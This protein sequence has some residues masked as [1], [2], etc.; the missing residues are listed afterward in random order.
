M[1]IQSQFLRVG[2]SVGFG[3]R[4]VCRSTSVLSMKES[5]AVEGVASQ[6]AVR[7]CPHWAPTTTA[8]GRS[9]VRVRFHII[10]HARIKNVGKYQACMVSKLPIV[11]KQTVPVRAPGANQLLQEEQ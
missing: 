11:W 8:A 9:I 6:Q 1:N 3:A 2:L 10:G 7:F 4:I 5:L